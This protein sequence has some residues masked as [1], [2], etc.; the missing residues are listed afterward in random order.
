[1]TVFCFCGWLVQKGFVKRVRIFFLSKGHTHVIIDQAFGRITKFI[2]NRSIF[3]VQQLLEA[4]VEVLSRGAVQGKK[5]TRLHHLYDWDTFFLKMDWN[6]GGFATNQFG[7]GYHEFM[8][9]LDDSDNAILD[10]KKYA[11]TDAWVEE[12]PFRIFKDGAFDVL[13]EKPNIADIKGE[14]CW[15]REDFCATCRC[16]EQYSGL[17]IQELE[18]VRRKWAETLDNTAAATSALRRENIIPFEEPKIDLLQ[19]VPQAER[20]VDF[21]SGASTSNPE[22]CTIHGGHRSKYTVQKE[23]E[24]WLVKNRGKFPVA[25]RPNATFPLFATDSC[26][27]TRVDL[28]RSWHAFPAVFR[29]SFHQKVPS[30]KS[31]ACFTVRSRTPRSTSSVPTSAGRVMVHQW[32]LAVAKSWCTMRPSCRQ[33]GRARWTVAS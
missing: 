14:E 10:A 19:A 16:Y 30:S 6:L 28:F 3:T 12:G 24:A 23:A 1:M 4:I 25:S 33:R 29:V 26:F 2:R 22:V 20:L 27:S 32:S 15:D 18:D 5:T 8:V 21:S 7:D 13:P 11:S 17:S 9:S 31:S